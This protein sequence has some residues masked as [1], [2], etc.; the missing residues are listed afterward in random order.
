MQTCV[1]E[2]PQTSHK[3]DDRHEKGLTLHMELPKLKKIDF[4]SLADEPMPQIKEV[5][6][7]WSH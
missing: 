5:G 4:M 1:H 6:L 7:R 3:L 2:H